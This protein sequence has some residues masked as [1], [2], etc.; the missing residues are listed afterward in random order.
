MSQSFLANIDNLKI[1]SY[2]HKYIPLKDFVVDNS[3]LFKIFK[4]EVI[5]LHN[6]FKESYVLDNINENI[7]EQ[8]VKHI[9]LRVFTVN[10]GIELLGNSLFI[11]KHCKN[12]VDD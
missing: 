3:G 6:D 2:S 12:L 11:E 7:A 1:K 10:H 5:H 8:L 4:N 9:A